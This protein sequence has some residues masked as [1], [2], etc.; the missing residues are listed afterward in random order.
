MGMAAVV[1]M[2]MIMIV[3]LFVI[4]IM[5]VV[6]IMF[7]P[8]LLYSMGCNGGLHWLAWCRWCLSLFLMGMAAVM[9]MVM[10]MVMTMFVLVS[11]FMIV[12]VVVIVFKLVLYC[13]WRG[14][15]GYG[16]FVSPSF[17]DLARPGGL[18]AG[19]LGPAVCCR[20]GG[21]IGD[22]GAGGDERRRDARCCGLYGLLLLWGLRGLQLS[23][24]RLLLAD[25]RIV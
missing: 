14:R 10:I 4:A 13:G 11:L 16:R 5:V 6:M 25:G 12:I 7:G 24:W 18:P 23:G 9:V 1:V 8:T 15:D 17:P 20:D 21:D 19:P 22:L 2:V 3:I